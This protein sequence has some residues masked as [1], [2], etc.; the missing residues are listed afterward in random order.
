MVSSA[1]LILIF[2]NRPIYYLFL[3]QK[4]F[5]LSCEQLVLHDTQR[6]LG[7]GARWR[8]KSEA[9]VFYVDRA[10]GDFLKRLAS[11]IALTGGHVEHWLSKV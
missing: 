7:P 4:H 3:V 6:F 1:V 8:I 5:V 2:V 10:I 9:Y 11:I